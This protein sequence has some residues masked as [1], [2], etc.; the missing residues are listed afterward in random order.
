MPKPAGELPGLA[1]SWD[2]HFGILL[3]G[4]AGGYL[5]HALKTATLFPTGTGLVG[6]VEFSFG[7]SLGLLAGYL[8]G[9]AALVET[10]ARRWSR[11]LA[12]L[13]AMGAGACFTCLAYSFF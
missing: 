4:A 13:V 8:P 11:T 10:R 9:K 2:V 3:A 7:A 5:S 12:L 1:P 6:V